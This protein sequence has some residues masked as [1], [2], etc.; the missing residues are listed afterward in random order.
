MFLFILIPSDFFAIIISHHQEIFLMKSFL[1]FN[2]T[3]HFFASTQAELETLVQAQFE[4]RMLV[5][6]KIGPNELLYIEEYALPLEDFMNHEAAWFY[7]TKMPEFVSL[8]DK[9]FVGNGDTK[10]V[11]L[12][13][14]YSFETGDTPHDAFSYFA[15]NSVNDFEA[16]FKAKALEAHKKDHLMIEYGAIGFNVSD[17]VY[18]D[19]KDVFVHAPLCFVAE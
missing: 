5:D 14:I 16:T 4:Q 12:T 10:L 6:E 9:H 19:K 1:F 13:P 3:V 11:V 2:N 18:K 7:S 15:V 8:E 17:Y